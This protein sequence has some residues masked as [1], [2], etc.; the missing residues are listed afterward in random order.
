MFRFIFEQLYIINWKINLL[1]QFSLKAKFITWCNW[2]TIAHKLYSCNKINKKAFY[3]TYHLLHYQG[4]NKQQ[5]ALKELKKIKFLILTN[6]KIIQIFKL[7]IM[8][9]KYSSPCF[10]LKNSYCTVFISVNRNLYACAFLWILWYIIVI[11]KTGNPS[12]FYSFVF[13]SAFKNYILL[14]CIAAPSLKKSYSVLDLILLISLKT[15]R[16]SLKKK[17]FI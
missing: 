8:K 9:L 2:M 7:L 12:L 4:D 14:I 15:E 17:E 10:G 16:N 11:L 6:F 5:T 13:L 3:E 1:L